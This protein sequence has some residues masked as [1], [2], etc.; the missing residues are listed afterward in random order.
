MKAM[1]L[2]AGVG[3]RMFPLALTQP[4]PSIPVLGRPLVVQI[5]HWLGLKGVDEAVLNLHHLP[6]GIKRILGDG[7]NPGLPVVH[8]SHEER[9]LGTAG[10]IRQAAPS[11]RGDGPI[12]VSN[13]D[14]LSN[15]DIAYVLDVHRASDC[16]ATLVLVPWRSGYSVVLRDAEGRVLSLGGE[17]RV[18]PA[19]AVGGQWLFTGCHVIDE[20]L[21]DRIPAERPSCI[22]RDVYRPLAAEGRLGS[23]LHEGFWWEF[24]SPE[25]YLDGCLRLLAEPAD[26]LPLISSEHDPIRPLGDAVAAVGPGAAFDDDVQFAGRVALGFSS[27]VSEGTRV[28]DSV[29][30]PE[31]WIGPRCRLERSVI[32]QGLELPAGS[33]AESQLVCVDPDPSLELPS[34]TRREAGLLYHSL[35]PTGA[36]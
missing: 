9:I 26:S 27:Y 25:L 12:V 21:I 22:V 33:E 3:R 1:L 11:L 35:A 7:V 32:G 6:E 2:T 16:L 10:G 8:Y 4:K 14:F 15:I 23:C 36:A 29:V 20:E 24:G 5:L 31:A 28:K 30:M 13:S 34:S 19:R 18:D 17:P